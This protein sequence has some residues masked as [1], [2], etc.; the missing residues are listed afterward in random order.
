MGLPKPAWPEVNIYRDDLS[1]KL[2]LELEMYESP[3]SNICR[4][5]NTHN[6]R[7]VRGDETYLL[8]VF[9]PWTGEELEVPKLET[10]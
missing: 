5:V 4:M 3:W 2:I 8:R 1:G 7:F 9:C 6:D 10:V